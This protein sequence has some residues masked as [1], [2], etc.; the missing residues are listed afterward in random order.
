M[1]RWLASLFLGVGRW[2]DPRPLQV[3]EEPVLTTPEQGEAEVFLRIRRLNEVVRFLPRDHYLWI[4]WSERPA[5][6]IVCK[7]DADRTVVFDGK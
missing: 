6:V 4:D 7:R 3:T 2:I 1:R 5:T